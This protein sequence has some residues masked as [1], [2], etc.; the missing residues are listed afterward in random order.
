MPMKAQGKK[1][2]ILATDGF[3][4]SELFSPKGAIEAAGG[5]VE[6]IS[7]KPGDIQ[8]LRHME[9]GRSIHVDKTVDQASPGDYDAILIPGGLFNP[10]RL[11]TDKGALKFASSFINDRK[12]VFA[13]CHGPQVLI[14][15]GVADGRKMTAVKSVQKDLEN[16]GAEVTD[17][18]VVVDHGLVTSRTPDDLDAFN[19][20]IVEE[21]CEGSHERH[22]HHYKLAFF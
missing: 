8:G 18:P 3:E 6:V 12:P 17:E 4:E 22:P 5:T 15:A 19:A 10:D 9:K 11:R 16:A 20:K 1:M 14:S 21:I 7:L 2:A 13:I